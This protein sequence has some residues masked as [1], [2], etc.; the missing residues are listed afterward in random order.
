MQELPPNV[1]E[2]IT[3]KFNQMMRLEELKMTEEEQRE[4]FKK[5]L[6]PGGRIAD[7]LREGMAAGAF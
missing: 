3:F 2:Y 6:H 7:W 5:E 4:F 1:R